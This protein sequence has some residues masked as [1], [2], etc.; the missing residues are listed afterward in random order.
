MLIRLIYDSNM[1][2]SFLALWKRV[3][4]TRKMASPAELQAPPAKAAGGDPVHSRPKASRKS[5]GDQERAVGD[6]G[7]VKISNLR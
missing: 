5:V 3:P 7:E 6:Q 2:T 4:K 1:L